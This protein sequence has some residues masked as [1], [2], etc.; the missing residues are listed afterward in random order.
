MGANKKPVF[1]PFQNPYANNTHLDSES[2]CTED[3]SEDISKYDLVELKKK[4]LELR[5]LISDWEDIIYDDM[6][7]YSESNFED[8][9]ARESLRSDRRSLQTL[10]TELR[11]V[12]GRR[13]RVMKTMPKELS[14][15]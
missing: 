9:G 13:V 12:R 8:D 4:E 15:A 7:S 14:I 5:E 1:T 10:K 2:V 3:C 6:A 11:E